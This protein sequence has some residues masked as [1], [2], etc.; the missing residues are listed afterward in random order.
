MSFPPGYFPH[1][2]LKV[3]VVCFLAVLELFDTLFYFVSTVYLKEFCLYFITHIIIVLRKAPLIISDKST[4]FRLALKMTVIS[5]QQTR[6]L[7]YKSK[8]ILAFIVSQSTSEDFCVYGF[9]CSSG[10]DSGSQFS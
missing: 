10:L 6:A 2:H 1:Y 5:F 9:S 3:K 7:N 4:F 8:Q